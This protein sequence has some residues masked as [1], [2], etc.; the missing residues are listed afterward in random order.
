MLTGCYYRQLGSADIT[1]GD[2]LPEVRDSLDF[3]RVAAAPGATLDSFRAHHDPGW[4]RANGLPDIILSTFQIFGF[5]DRVVTQWAGPATFICRRKA[6]LGAPVCPGDTLVGQGRVVG[7]ATDG[8]FDVEVVVRNHR[9]EICCPAELRI[10][11]P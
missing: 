10:R 8:S 9:G 11:V 5:V 6:R 1:V 3:T 2:E 7:Q 4:A